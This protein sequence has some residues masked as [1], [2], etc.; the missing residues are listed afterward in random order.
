MST[1][2]NGCITINENDQELDRSTPT[3]AAG[4]VNITTPVAAKR[5]FFELHFWGHASSTNQDIF[6]KFGV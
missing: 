6:T 3:G 1:S 2:P 5:C 4:P